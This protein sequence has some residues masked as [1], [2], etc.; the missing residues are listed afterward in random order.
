MPCCEQDP[1]KHPTAKL[2]AKELL[3]DSRGSLLFNAEFK[4]SIEIYGHYETDH[5]R[6]FIWHT[7]TKKKKKTYKKAWLFPKA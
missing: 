6:L 1:V 3:P 2:S 7:F 4:V 5:I